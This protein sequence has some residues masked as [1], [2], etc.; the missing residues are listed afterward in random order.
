[1]M[2]LCY[3]GI[4]AVYAVFLAGIMQQCVDGGRIISQDY[5][6]VILFPFLLIISV[7]KSLADM[8]IISVIGNILIITAGTI[9]IVYAL[10]DGIGDTWVIIGSDFSS[11]AKFVGMVFFSMCSPGLVS[12][13][14]KARVKQD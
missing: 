1:M 6:I 9:G 14:S 7:M 12:R 3:V 8:T 11:Y 13:P 5:Y 2:L 4:G 10:K